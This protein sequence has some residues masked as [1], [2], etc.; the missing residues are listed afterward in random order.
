[1]ADPRPRSEGFLRGSRSLRILL[2]SIVGLTV[3]AG[4]VTFLTWPTAPRLSAERAGDA[5]LIQRLE[6]AKGLS[7][8][9]VAVVEPG[10]P[11][12]YADFGSSPQTRFEAGSISK[13]LTGLVVADSVRRGELALD[14]PVSR[15]LG[16]EGA[17]DATIQQLVTQSA[18]YPRLGGA[19]MRRGLVSGLTGGNPY[20]TTLPA[21]LKETGGAKPADRGTYAYSNLGAAVV[22]Q[23]AAAAAGMSYPELMRTRLFEPLG[24]TATSVQTPDSDAP[25]VPRGQAARG[26][27]VAP[28]VFDGY[29]PAGGV[30]T[31]S[32]DLA[33][34][35]SALLDG[36]APGQEALTPIT[37]T[38]PD[39]TAEI[40]M[41]WMTSP[42]DESRTMVWHNGMTG[43][44]SSFLG[45]DLERKRAVVVLSNVATSVDGVAVDLLKNPA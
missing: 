34:L 17:G 16:V 28:W 32:E 33:R 38:G 27:T 21:M 35:A 44:Y 30:V 45:L 37:G 29:A 11:V 5:A 13:A 43:G 14:A 7:S 31:T 22:G 15:Y 24:M 41:F 10:G 1:M 40:G 4:V 8:L 20:T 25:V 9:S 26:N 2:V 42:L 12:R 18:G 19:T 6:G 23:A 3:I 39:S 36:S